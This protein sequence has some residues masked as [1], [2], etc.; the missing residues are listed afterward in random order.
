MTGSQYGSVLMPMYGSVQS[1]NNAKLRAEGADLLGRAGDAAGSRPV[2]SVL[3][4]A[5]RRCRL[6]EGEALLL[7]INDPLE[8]RSRL[9]EVLARSCFVFAAGFAASPR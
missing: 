1:F 5:G 4:A 8:L 6:L 9:D 7:R 3:T 2:Q